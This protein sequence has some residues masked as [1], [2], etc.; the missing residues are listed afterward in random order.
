MIKKHFKKIL[1]V[2]LC[3]LIVI[4]YSITRIHTKS[5]FQEVNSE[6]NDVIYNIDIDTLPFTQ[7]E[8]YAQIF[9][10]NNII[11][12]SI[13]ITNSEIKKLQ[14]DFEQYKKSSIYRMANVTISITIPDD[15]TYKYYIE[16]AGIRL[17]GNTSKESLYSE[18]NGIL[19]LN[20][21]KINFNETF[22]DTQDGYLNGEYYIDSNGSS[23]WDKGARKERKNRVFGNMEKFDVKWNR[24]L[25]STYL[26]EYYANE[27][28]RSEGIAA[29]HIGLT[30]MEINVKNKQKNSEYLNK[31]LL[32]IKDAV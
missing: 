7:E 6:E 10:I 23:T 17:K 3:I 19:N 5:T 14:K 22:D 30:T 18:A 24:H 9:D 27:I 2:L 26:R 31:I 11:S 8:L 15:K 29:P 21:F 28:F 16:E 4:A 25:D 20:H 12:V 1:L 13:D 32:T